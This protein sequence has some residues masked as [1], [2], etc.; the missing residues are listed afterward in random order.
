MW[1]RVVEFMLACWLALSPFILRYPA[2]DTFLW[3]NDFICASLVALFALLSF[4][5]PLR[6]IHL[7]TLGV[8]LWLWG[9]GYTS[10]PGITPPPQEN[11]VVIGLMLLML[12]II[13]SHSHHTTLSWQEFID[14]KK[15]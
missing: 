11:S 13:P 6:K 3:A 1:A 4:W 15:K 5:H 7:M 10:L 12:A 9:L 2:E 14:N 8:A